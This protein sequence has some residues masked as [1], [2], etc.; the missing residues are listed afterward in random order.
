VSIYGVRITKTNEGLQE[1]PRPSASMRRDPIRAIPRAIRAY[2][3]WGGRLAK[4]F[5]KVTTRLSQISSKVGTESSSSKIG[6]ATISEPR[7]G[8]EAC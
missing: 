7:Q 5:Q 4:E 8:D 3:L 6:V 2:R 1:G